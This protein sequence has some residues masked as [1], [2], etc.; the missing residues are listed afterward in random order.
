[1]PEASSSSAAA[2]SVTMREFSIAIAALLLLALTLM[3]GRVNALVVLI[4][5]GKETLPFP[6][7]EAAFG[8]GVPEGGLSGV[9]QFVHDGCDPMS[10][11]PFSNNTSFLPIALAARGKCLFEDKVLHAQNAGYAAVIVYNTEDFPSLVTMSGDP[12][13]IRIPAVFV[14]K[15]AGEALLSYYNLNGTTC[16]ILPSMESSARSLLAATLVLLLSGMVTSL[17]LFLIRRYRLRTIGSRVLFLRESLGMNLRDL[18]LLP[19]LIYRANSVSSETCAICLEDYIADEKLRVLPCQHE[20]HATCVDHW[21][22]TRRSFC[23]ICKR[24]AHSR[25]NDP[26]ATENTPL[27]EVHRSDRAILPEVVISLRGSSQVHH[28]ASDTA[29]QLLMSADR[30]TR[31]ENV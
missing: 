21:L 19:T 17:L 25:V 5:A 30:Q 16:Y 29:L 31:V 11:P 14:S 2:L 22:T 6:D 23:P 20:F 10:S 27:L 12:Q 18:K 9:L 24:D 1:M 7:V 26:P 28:V 4:T 15:A 8:P 3:L 13:G